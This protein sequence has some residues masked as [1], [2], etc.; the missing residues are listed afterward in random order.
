[1][2]KNQRKGRKFPIHKGLGELDLLKICNN[3]SKMNLF[4]NEYGGKLLLI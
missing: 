4:I 2:Y 1:M 3:N